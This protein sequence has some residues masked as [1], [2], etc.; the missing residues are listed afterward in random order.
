MELTLYDFSQALPLNYPLNFADHDERVTS[1]EEGLLVARLHLICSLVRDLYHFKLLPHLDDNKLKWR[2]INDGVVSSDE[3]RGSSWSL[4]MPIGMIERLVRYMLPL[5]IAHDEI[6]RDS[7]FHCPC[8]SE[9]L[10]PA[11]FAKVSNL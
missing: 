8:W 11:G 5:F 2:N 4:V 3:V 1:E 10:P 9:L 6:C 7:S